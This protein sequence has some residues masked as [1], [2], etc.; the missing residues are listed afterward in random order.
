MSKILVNDCDNPTIN[1]ITNF[2]SSKAEII[3]RPFS[4]DLDITEFDMVLLGADGDRETILDKLKHIRYGARFRN[5]PILLLNPKKSR[6]QKQ[7]PFLTGAA[8]ILS[9]EEPPEALAQMLQG[10]LMPSRQPKK[11]EME[12]LTPFIESTKQVFSTMGSMTTN[13]KGVYFKNDYNLLGDV[14]GIIG[15]SGN[16]EGMVVITFYWDLAQKIIS[17]IMGVEEEEISPELINDGVGELINMIS[18][19]AKR[20]LSESPYLFQLSLPT[21]FVGWQHEIGHPEKA[22]VAVL[23]FDIEEKSFAI[24]VSLTAKDQQNR[25]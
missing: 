17:S 11:F 13:Y 14:S 10:Y 18:G 19:A 2:M 12:Y 9:I 22:S 23:M 3:N 1:A 7:F 16:A 15:L 25:R 4:R 21:V 5:I 6:D 24:Q 8:S 20:Y